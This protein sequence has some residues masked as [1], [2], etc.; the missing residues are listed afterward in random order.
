MIHCYLPPANKVWGEVIFFTSLLLCQSPPEN[1]GLTAI[2]ITVLMLPLTPGRH[3]FPSI[4]YVQLNSTFYL[5]C[6]TKFLKILNDFVANNTQ[7]T[8]SDN[9]SKKLYNNCR[10]VLLFTQFIC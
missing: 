9:I 7:L 2:G 1:S 5:L 8:K 4:F 6:S 3:L 10:K